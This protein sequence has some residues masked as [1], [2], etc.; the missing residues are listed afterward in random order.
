M[1]LPDQS[2]STTPV[3]AIKAYCLQCCLESAMEV[4]LCP[5]E[6]CPLHPFRQGKNP[7]YKARKLTEEQKQRN[8]ER[9]RM[10]NSQKSQQTVGNS[11]SDSFS[12]INSHLDPAFDESSINN[13]HYPTYP[14]FPE[15][16]DGSS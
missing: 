14:N 12:S 13:G 2:H 9:L 3:K 4:K 1:N 10:F 11:E 7:F 5:S 15:E 8:I 6:E 16:G